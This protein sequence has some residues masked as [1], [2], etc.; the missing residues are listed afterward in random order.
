MVF[1]LPSSILHQLRVFVGMSICCVLLVILFDGKQWNL[2]KF[3]VFGLLSVASFTL[4]FFLVYIFFV[5]FFFF[6]VLIWHPC[7]DQ[8]KERL[9]LLLLLL[10]VF[11]FIFSFLFF[12]FFRIYG[13]RR[14]RSGR[15]KTKK[16][17]NERKWLFFFLFVQMKNSKQKKVFLPFFLPIKLFTGFILWI[18]IINI[19]WRITVMKVHK[20]THKKKTT[21]KYYAYLCFW[22]LNY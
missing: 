13:R 6:E 22:M 5:I 21:A 10:F 15:M 14:K 9:I 8:G 12:F 18:K 1:V 17:I 3:P 19:Y 2:C 20:H 7:C 11:V 16:E 4:L